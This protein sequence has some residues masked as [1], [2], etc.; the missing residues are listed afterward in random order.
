MERKTLLVASMILSILSQAA[1]GDVE[2]PAVIC[3]NM[4]LQRNDGVAIWGWADPG[5]LV[6]VKGSWTSPDSG[7]SA[8]AV[9]DGRTVVVS[10]D[11]VGPTLSGSVCL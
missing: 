8:R 7:A 11:K 1:P 5:E 9:I 2:L 3:D 6:Q 4:V 10:S